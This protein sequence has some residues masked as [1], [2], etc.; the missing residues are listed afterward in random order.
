MIEIGFIALARSIGFGIF[1]QITGLYY[2]KIGI[3]KLIVI[4]TVLG[5]LSIFLFSFCFFN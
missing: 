2:D 3:K 4:G 5:T 1:E